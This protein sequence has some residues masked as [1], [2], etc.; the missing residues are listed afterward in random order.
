ME[1]VGRSLDHVGYGDFFQPIRREWCWNRRA[2]EDTIA[3]VIYRQPFERALPCRS[4]D[5]TRQAD[6]ARDMERAGIEADDEIAL[7]QRCGELRDGRLPCQRNP[8]VRQFLSQ[9]VDGGC[10]RSGTNKYRNC[11]GYLCEPADD[12]LESFIAPAI[13]LTAAVLGN[14]C[15]AR[16]AGRLRFSLQQCSCVVGILLRKKYPGLGE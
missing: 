14:E 10:V 4:K 9:R 6:G 15:D 12:L 1:E 11:I 5:D 16:G 13:G 2:P 7:R 3:R 8:H